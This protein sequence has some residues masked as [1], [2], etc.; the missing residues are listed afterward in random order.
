[1]RFALIA[2][3]AGAVSAETTLTYKVE[4]RLVEAGKVTLNWKPAGSPMSGEALLAMESSGLVARLY[5]VSNSYR[6]RMADQY[7][8]VSGAM[9]SNEGS[10]RRETQHTY[11]RERK[12]AYYLERDLTND[13]ILREAEVDLPLNC[14]HDVVGGLMAMRG[15]KLDVGKSINLPVSDGKKFAFVKVEA[16]A[17]ETIATPMGQVDTTMCEV[18]LLNDVVYGRKGRVFVWLANDERRLPVQIRVRLQLLIGTI[19]LQ[20]TS[21]ET[22]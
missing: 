16:L 15:M 11:D 6:I 22:K 4:W 21:E 13:R 9:Q 17:K 19:T 7:C 12:K 18:F 3:L 10:R 5:K 1:L 14:V 2:L 8:A 20:L